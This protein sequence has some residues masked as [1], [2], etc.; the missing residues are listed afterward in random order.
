MRMLEAGGKPVLVDQ[1]RSAD[2][3]NP[4]GYFEFEAVK[5]TKQDASWLDGS[6]GRA[7]KMVYRLLYD[8]PVNRDYRVLFMRRNLKEVLASQR[9][10]LKRK[11]PHGESADD[12]QM[13]SLFRRELQ[14]FYIWVQKQRH[15]SMMDVDYNRIQQDPV[16]ELARVHRFLGGIVDIN[17]M[18]SVVDPNLYRNRAREAQ[19]NPTK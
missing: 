15:I 2:E 14:A 9:A 17:A 13:E 7:V 5:R 19:A 4:N 16:A 12:G 1:V 10:M 3:D 6:E 8:L 11:D 18:A